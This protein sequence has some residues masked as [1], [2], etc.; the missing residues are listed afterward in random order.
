MPVCSGCKQEEDLIANV[1]RILLESTS[2]P[3]HEDRDCELAF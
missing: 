3:Q 1:S 2:H